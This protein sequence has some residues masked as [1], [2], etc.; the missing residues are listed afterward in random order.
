MGRTVTV[1]ERHLLVAVLVDAARCLH[2][3]DERARAEVLAWIRHPRGPARLPL[4]AVCD[5]LN[6]EVGMVVKRL[7]ATTDDG[8]R[9][10]HRTRSQPNRKIVHVA[11]QRQ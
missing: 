5:G 3:N 10:L 9:R 1:P 11:G 2:A 8:P 7:L 6:L 4:S